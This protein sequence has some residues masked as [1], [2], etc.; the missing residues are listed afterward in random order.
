MTKEYRSSLLSQ[1]NLGIEDTEILPEDE[2][3][4]LY[5]DL[6]RVWTGNGHFS[7]ARLQTLWILMI[8][9]CRFR[10]DE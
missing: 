1:K 7:K 6:N 4:L 9:L 8:Q 5:D 3:A 10:R 2:K